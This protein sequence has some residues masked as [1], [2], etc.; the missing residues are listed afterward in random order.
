MHFY[1]FNI[2]DYA[3]HTKH[4]SL[5][6]DLA[7]RRLIDLYYLNERPL[8]GCP[9]DVARSIGMREQLEAVQ[10]VLT[11]FFSESE[12][13]FSQK[14]IDAEIAHYQDKA[15][16]A[17]AAGKASAAKRS[18]AASDGPTL[19]GRSTDDE[20]N[21]KQETGTKNQ[22][23]TDGFDEFWKAYPKKS[24]KPAALKAFKAAKING[25]LPDVLADIAS[26]SQSEAWTKGGGQFI[27]MP[28]TYLNQRRWEDETGKAPDNHLGVYL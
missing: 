27:P 21:K 9:T 2:G 19:N 28:S 7:Y 20:L 6:E 23:P 10:Y 16:K 3:S 12:G 11:T 13:E 25:H 1:P 22:E 15:Q 4:L 18:K 26:K 14:R 24:A 17:S 8:S 5:M